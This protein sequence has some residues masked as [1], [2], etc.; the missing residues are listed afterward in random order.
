MGLNYFE[1]E[2]RQLPAVAAYRRVGRSIGGSEL[3]EV[4]DVLWLQVG[5]KFAD[6]RFP[7]AEQTFSVPLD[8]SQAFSGTFSV[9][10]D[11]MAWIHD[12]DTVVRPSGGM[13]EARFDWSDGNLVEI[14]DDYVEHWDPS[15]QPLAVPSQVAECFAIPEDSAAT[16]L[17]RVITA[18]VVRIGSLAVAVWFR[19][20]PGGALLVS[21]PQ[22]RVVSTIG[23]QATGVDLV[24]LV[25]ALASEVQLPFG[26]ELVVEDSQ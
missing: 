11:R 10:G 22:W 2:V 6:I 5:T 17:E 14:G 26:W 23:N 7:R 21:D 12:L 9:I 13:E 24:V 25:G 18:R 4:S 3:A 1:P 8:I 20:W 15:A 16:S 19:P